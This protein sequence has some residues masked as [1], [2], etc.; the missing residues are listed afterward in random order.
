VQFDLNDIQR[1]I[2]K[3]AREFAEKEFDPDLALT[4]DREGTFPGTIY[5]RACRLGFV[6]IDY[7]EAYGGQSLGL[8]ENVLVTEEFCRRDSGIGIS[9][10]MADRASGLILRHGNEE[11]KK[12][13]IAPVT[14]GKATNS[15]AVADS[16]NVRTQARA[17]GSGYVVNGKKSFVLT[18]PGESII[19][20]LCEIPADPNPEVSGAVM[21]IVRKDQEG[22]TL[23]ERKRMMGAR[24]SS[25]HE[26]SFDQVR[27]PGDLRI[28]EVGRAMES[29]APYLVEERIKTAAQTL[30]VAQGAFD[31]AVKHAREREQFG[32]KIGQ[33]QGIQFMLS[34]MFTQIEAARSL[35]YRAARSCDAA[36][37]ERESLSSMARLFSADVAVRTA[38][39]SIQIHGGVGLMKEYS[40]ERMFRDVKTIQNLGETGLVQKAVIGK[41]LIP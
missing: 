29:L 13:F 1:D 12:R 3:A 24:M 40:I 31:Q 35:V 4:L 18:G 22:I 17:E 9:I 21:L 11:Q 33:F 26:L 2:Q 19:V 23:S 36:S 28:G 38:L 7:P 5:E 10:G 14:Q 20:L 25:F 16:F 32:R 37:P 34:Q 6:G 39:D 27:V 15:V 41:T 30:G 8:F